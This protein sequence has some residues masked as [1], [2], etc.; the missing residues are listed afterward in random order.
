MNKF[1]R[2]SLMALMAIVFGSASAEDVFTA[3]FSYATGDAFTGG[4]DGTFTGNI[5]SNKIQAN[6]A[7]DDALKD[8]YA[9]FLEKWNNS[10]LSNAYWANLSVRLGTSSKDGTLTTI[11]LGEKMT[12]KVKVT[13]NVAGWGT[14]TNSMTLVASKGTVADATVE[15]ANGEFKDFSFTISGGDATTTISITGKRMFIK[16]VKVETVA[17]SGEGGGGEGGT[18]EK[19][20]AC[21]GATTTLK[22]AFSSVVNES[23]VATNEANGRSVVK[24]DNTALVFKAVSGAVP[25]DAELIPNKSVVIDE[26]LH[27]FGITSTTWDDIKWTNG[28]NFGDDPD[29]PMYFVNGTGVPF[30]KICAEQVYKDGEAT[31]KYRPYYYYYVKDGSNGLP[32]TGVYYKFTPKASGTLKVG[33]WVN[34]QDR[35]TFVV[36][37]STKQ[38]IDYNVEGYI[39]GVNYT[40]DDAPSEA[41][42]GKMKKLTNAEIVAIHNEYVESKKT[43]NKNK[44]K[45][46]GETPYYTEEELAVANAQVDADQEYVIGKNTAFRGYITIEVEKGEGYLFFVQNAQMGFCSYELTYTGE[47]DATVQDKDELA[48][49]GDAKNLENVIISGINTISTNINNTNAQMYNLS[50]QKVDKSYKGIVIQNGRKFVNK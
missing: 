2:F 11:A 9:K 48:G 15:L 18:S 32:M 27:L 45:A 3:D 36:K 39:N 46:D 40:A 49:M 29:N 43:A 1:L 25:L 21:E 6:N 47:L 22:A 31:D 8:A 7:N 38:A 10:D 37:E 33:V 23:G 5:A 13:I 41:L 4:G 34:K 26:A 28:N 17:D 19:W 35:K 14:G 44:K 24:V 12:S 50:G 16:S 20:T 42:V 30:T